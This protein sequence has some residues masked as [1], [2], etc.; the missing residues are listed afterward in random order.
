MRTT[1]VI[2]DELLKKASKLTGIKEKTSIVRLGLE[3]LIARESARRLALLGG[4]QKKLE[5]ISRRRSEKA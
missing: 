1:L 3:A 2:E 4:T 5:D